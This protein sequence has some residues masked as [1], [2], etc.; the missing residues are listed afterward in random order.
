MK[1][2][3]GITLLFFGQSLNLPGIRGRGGILI[4]LNLSDIIG[5]HGSRNILPLEEGS[6]LSFVVSDDGGIGLKESASLL[7][8]LLEEAMT[9]IMS[10]K[11]QFL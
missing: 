4:N 5:D 6:I 7:L 8:S 9:S 10:G 3:D 11:G 1:V 2:D